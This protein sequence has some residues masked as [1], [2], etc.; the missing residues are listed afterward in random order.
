[1]GAITYLVPPISVALGWLLLEESPPALALVGGAV[2]L[3]GVLVA[4]RR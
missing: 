1:M 3:A 2:C 4:R